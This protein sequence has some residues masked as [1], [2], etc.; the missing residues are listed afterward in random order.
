MGRRTTPKPKPKPKRSI[1][2]LLIVVSPFL[3]LLLVM[4]GSGSSGNSGSSGP[5][6]VSN[7]R[8]FTM[9]VETLPIVAKE[10]ALEEYQRS[11]KPVVIKSPAG[12]V[13]AEAP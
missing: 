6:P 12:Q 3:L 2:P 9:P 4:M 1:F 7:V 5:A 13:L 11:G 10:R 8:H